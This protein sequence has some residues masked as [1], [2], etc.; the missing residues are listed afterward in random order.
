MTPAM[1]GVVP[2]AVA[3]SLTRAAATVPVVAVRLLEQ[4]RAARTVTATVVS[5]RLKRPVLPGRLTRPR[6]PGGARSSDRL[7]QMSGNRERLALFLTHM[8][9]HF[10]CLLQKL[11]HRLSWPLSGVCVH[12]VSWGGTTE[13]SQWQYVSRRL[14]IV[15]PE[16]LQHASV[17]GMYGI[18]ATGCRRAKC[19]Q[20]ARPKQIARK[21]Q[22]GGTSCSR[23]NKQPSD[24]L[25]ERPLGTVRRPGRLAQQ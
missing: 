12:F 7:G 1:V 17:R 6:A 16:V 21:E 25:G 14:V 22:K 19:W 10:A 23:R 4:S 18:R 24:V 2:A 9:C 11:Q 8:L 13:I 20:L 15:N 3:V 5:R